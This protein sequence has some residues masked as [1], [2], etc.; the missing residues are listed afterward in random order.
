MKPKG[1]YDFI[2]LHVV[3][4]FM[5]NAL[6]NSHEDILLLPIRRSVQPMSVIHWAKTNYTSVVESI[7][8]QGSY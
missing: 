3:N 1:S 5:N 4:Q 2:F 8:Y 7:A 6:K